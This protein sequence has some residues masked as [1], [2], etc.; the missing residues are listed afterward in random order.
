[1]ALAWD[2]MSAHGSE[3]RFLLSENAP[4]RAVVEELIA[5]YT[6]NE[7]PRKSPYAQAGYLDIWMVPKWG[8]YS[9]SDVRTM[10][11]EAWLGTLKQ[12]ANGIRA[13]LWNIMSDRCDDNSR[14]DGSLNPTRS[15]QSEIHAR[16]AP[17]RNQIAMMASEIKPC[18]P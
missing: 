11:V 4:W 12:L 8:N 3:E 7:L 15:W 6:K 18:C 16:S 1:M 13:K 17:A 9:L 14:C 5:N 10:Q 2:P